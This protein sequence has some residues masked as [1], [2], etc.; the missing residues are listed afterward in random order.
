MALSSP[1]GGAVHASMETTDTPTSG[2]DEASSNFPKRRKTSSGKYRRPREHVNPLSTLYQRPLE[3]DPNDT[4]FDNPDRPLHL[5]IGSASGTFCL[6]MAKKHPEMNFLGLEIRKTIAEHAVKKREQ[7][8]LRNVHFLTG[9]ANVDLE[10]VLAHMSKINP[11][12]MKRVTIMFPDPC[13]KKRHWK[14]RV[15]T[16]ELVALISKYLNPGTGEVFLQSDVLSAAEHMRQTFRDDGS[17]VDLHE[18]MEEW[19]HD[20]NPMGVPTER[21]LGRIAGDE[22]VYRCLFRKKE[23]QTGE[24]GSVRESGPCTVHSL[25]DG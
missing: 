3:I 2:M 1:D 19:M 11:S 23:I 24:E 13:F 12:G 25:N 10:N 21:E 5:D 4:F 8:G 14:R 17:L 6:E 16:P 15:T 18:S 7:S 22:L 20:D 9:N